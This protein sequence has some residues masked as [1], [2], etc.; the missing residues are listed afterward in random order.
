MAVPECV[1]RSHEDDHVHVFLNGKKKKKE[2]QVLKFVHGFFFLDMRRWDNRVV[3]AFA[4]LW[5]I[6]V[7]ILK[8]VLRQGENVGIL[9]LLCI[10]QCQDIDQTWETENIFLFLP[11]HISIF[12]MHYAKHKYVIM[13]KEY[14]I[15]CNTQI[16]WC[17]ILCNVFFYMSSCI[18]ILFSVMGTLALY[19]FFL[20]CLVFI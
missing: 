19:L 9:F 18:P 2:L 17:D 4:Y 3:F 15:P 8:D 5:L 14:Y 7:T 11:S 20:L 12:A 13:P 1:R 16:G 10:A 6:Y